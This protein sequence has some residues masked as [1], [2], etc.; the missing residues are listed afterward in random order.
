MPSPNPTNPNAD[1]ETLLSAHHLSKPLT[2]TQTLAKTCKLVIKLPIM[3]TL[4]PI[5]I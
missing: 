5:M 3:Q 4:S 2:L 1:N